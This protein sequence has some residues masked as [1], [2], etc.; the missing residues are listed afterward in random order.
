MC[1][2]E[3]EETWGKFPMQHTERERERERE[4]GGAERG[5]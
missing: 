5:G 3:D 4:V 2:S 1:A